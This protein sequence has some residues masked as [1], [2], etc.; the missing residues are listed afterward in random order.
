VRE[1]GSDGL[2]N[3]KGQGQ[4]KRCAHFLRGRSGSLLETVV[5]LVLMI[6]L[7]TAFVTRL[8]VSR[9]SAL[10]LFAAR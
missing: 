10:G 9:A 2:A 1:V 7:S 4:E 8:L 5:I 6:V 3:N